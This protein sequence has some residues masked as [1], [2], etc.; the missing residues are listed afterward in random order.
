MLALVFATLLI[1]LFIGL[2]IFVAL[3]GLSMILLMSNHTPGISIAQVVIDKLNGETILA[4]PFF[5]MAAQFM[6]RG[7]IA[8]SLIAMAEAWLGWLRGGLALTCVGATTVFAAVSGSS[9][10]TALAMATILVPAMLARGYD[11]PFAV[12][13]VGASGTLGILIPPSIILVIYGLIAEASI[14]RLF[15]AGIIPGLLQG[16]LFAAFILFYAHRKQLP[17]TAPPTL[18]EFAQ[19]NLAALPAVLIPVVIFVGIYGGYA[20]IAEA[21]G[22]AAFLAIFVSLVVYR[23]CTLR[24][25]IPITAV[26]LRRS[27]AIIMIVVAALLFGHW[28]TETRMPVKLVEF[29]TAIDLEAWQFLIIMSAIM[30]ILG[31]V[32]EGLSIVLI[33][34]PLVLPLLH[35]FNI[36][37]VHYAIIVVIN[38]EMA[39]LTPPVGLNLFVL[40]SVSKAPVSEVIKGILPFL[41]LMAILLLAVTFVPALSLFLPA[42]ILN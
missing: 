22:L 23:G 31:T 34:V 15:L 33:T 27:A 21:A 38:I 41:G 12:G 32:L 42:V 18:K 7:G 30:L 16:A 28:L 11:R 25:V 19:A 6:E 4:V 3:G 29:V 14:P 8:K 35:Q 9:V 13:V 40:S 24:E 36:D 39:M 20:T 1:L 2:P 26:A 37:P 17:R 10:A 5:V